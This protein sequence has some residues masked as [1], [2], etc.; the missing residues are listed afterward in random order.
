MDGV[1]L[2]VAEKG[3][4]PVLERFLR[5]SLA[6]ITFPLVTFFSVLKAMQGEKLGSFVLNIMG[7]PETVHS[8]MT[9]AALSAVLV[10]NIILFV[11]VVAALIEDSKLAN[12]PTPHPQIESTTTTVNRTHE[13]ASDNTS[14]TSSTLVEESE[15]SINP[16]DKKTN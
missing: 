11:F 13:I 15:G 5:F 4:R 8:R 1:R 3:N 16:V 10:V 2:I 14:I 6:L 7:M 12:N 9:V